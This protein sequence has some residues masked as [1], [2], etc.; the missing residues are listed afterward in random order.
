MKKILSVILAVALTANLSGFV[1]SAPVRPDSPVKPETPVVIVT[2]Y[3]STNLFID[4][5]SENRKQV[6]KLETDVLIP[7]LLS[8]SFGII[9]DA[10][11]EHKGS[12]NL[13]ADIAGPLVREVFEPLA[14][15]E[16]GNSLYNVSPYPTGVENTRYDVIRKM[17]G[18]FIPEYQCME[19]ISARIGEKNLYLCT[20]DWRHGMVDCA[21]VLDKYLDDVRNITGSSKVDLMGI[22]FGG[23][24]IGTYL[25]LYEDTGIDNV[26]LNVPALD[27]TSIAAQLLSGDKLNIRYSEMMNFYM[28]LE[29][30]E[31][32]NDLLFLTDIMDLN[33]LDSTVREIVRNYLFDIFVNFGSVW[34]FVTKDKYEALKAQYLSSGKYASLIEKSDIYHH[35]V[36]G[37]F[38][39]TFG[40]CQEKGIDVFIVAGCG[41][42][43]LT[44]CG[45]DS[46]GVLDLIC[47]TGAVAPGAGQM[48]CGNKSHYHISPDRTVDASTGFLP[49]RTWFV[50]GLMH[51]Q[52][53]WDD[54]STELIMKL[55]L[56]DEISDVY[57]DDR[58]PQFMF[59][60]NPGKIAAGEFNASKSG[61]ITKYDT[62]FTVT[63]LSRIYSITV[64]DVSC[65][66]AGL[67]FDTN[68][69]V[70]LL[71]GKSI[72]FAVHG[73]VP[74]GACVSDIKIEYIRYAEKAPLLESRTL[75][76]CSLGNGC[77]LDPVIKADAD[78]GKLMDNGPRA[79]KRTITAD[80]ILAKLIY[81]LEWIATLQAKI[82]G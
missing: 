47:T 73:S 50:D 32:Y 17:G 24:V 60:Q 69:T 45:G 10:A 41:Y 71:P 23:G 48:H 37:K 58:Y 13:L 66:G 35:Q 53:Y 20:L 21:A 72:Y 8:E 30:D 49:D 3:S 22:S 15:D 75:T 59:A 26:V 33:L 76:H 65:K 70:K 77:F 36:Q 38:A 44:G 7:Q 42:D 40:K 78:T 51:G 62:V 68:N 57:T 29:R 54:I 34:D 4:A 12:L 52:S 81:I 74:S 25:T 39:E 2:G 16:E 46:D 9:A 19:S 31:T 6:W 56:T 18:E 61:Y 1:F 55:L 5:D 28:E 11:K 80:Y 63:N 82:F 64:E 27:G 43:L 79:V 67:I 14:L